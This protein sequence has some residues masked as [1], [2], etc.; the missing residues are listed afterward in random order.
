M[1]LEDETGIA[2]LIVWPK[3][4]ER[5]R[6]IVIGARFVVATGKLQ[7]ES[8]VVHLIVERMEDLTPMLGL[9][10]REDSEADRSAFAEAP[11]LAA[12]RRQGDRF[13]QRSSST[14][15]A[16][17]RRPSSATP[18]APCRRAGAFIEAA[19]YAT[20]PGAGARLSPKIIARTRFSRWRRLASTTPT[21]WART[22]KASPC[23]I[24]ECSRC[25]PSEPHKASVVSA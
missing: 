8:G 23:A 15:R 2:N 4:F 6:A 21:R 10:S 13:A 18:S 19:S 20:S 22:S 16:C 24:N 11:P 25:A 9:L 14:T 7:S 17:R 3:A 1:T 12:P 5:L